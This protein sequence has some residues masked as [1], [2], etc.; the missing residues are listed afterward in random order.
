MN[1]ADLLELYRRLL[2]A[3]GPQHWWPA[4]GRFEMIVGAILTQR[5]AWR[6]AAKALD[7]LRRAGYLTADALHRAPEAEIAQCIRPAVY[8]N[9]KAR[10]LKALATH[11]YERHGGE[12]DRLLDQPMDA[13]RKELLSIWGIG[14]ETADAI[15]LYAAHRPSFVVDAY[16]TRLMERL[17]WL[18]QGAGYARVRRAFMDALPPDVELYNEF[19]ALI[20]RHGKEHCR[21]TPSCDGCPVRPLCSVGSKDESEGENATV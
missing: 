20:V 11:L 7:G 3:Y 9:A 13:L 1:T 5:A 6:N 16:T 18:P 14:P 4:R 10:K 12:L 15:V 21:A 8:H 19:H 17:G 2:D